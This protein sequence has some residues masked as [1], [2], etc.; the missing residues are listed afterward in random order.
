MSEMTTEQNAVFE[1][2]AARG[3]VT[4][5]T[6]TEFIHR[7]LW[8]LQEELAELFD[9]A[10]YNELHDLDSSEA[11]DAIDEIG[12]KVEEAGGT[13][14]DYFTYKNPDLYALLPKLVMDPKQ[15]GDEL[16][17]LQ[18]VVFCLAEMLRALPGLADFNV[19]DHALAKA[20]ID[21]RRGVRK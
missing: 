10:G 7:Q 11:C 19:V 5:W 6:Q 3:Y 21:I 18:V 14:Y 2:V 16:A 4:G 15:F 17:D 13:A 12:G 9:A 1:A 8:K 20:R